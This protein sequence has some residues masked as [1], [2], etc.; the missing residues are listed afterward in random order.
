MRCL[1]LVCEKN[2]GLPG[3]RKKVCPFFEDWR[4]ELTERFQVGV[5]TS[6]HGLRGEVKVFPYNR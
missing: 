6:T 1:L 5:I 4:E 3:L 2:V